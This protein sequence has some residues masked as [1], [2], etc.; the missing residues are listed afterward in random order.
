MAA[1]SALPMLVPMP[2]ASQ[3]K[4]RE[5]LH[6]E[7][8]RCGVGE[9]QAHQFLAQGRRD[10]TNMSAKAEAGRQPTDRRTTG[11]RSEGRWRRR[12]GGRA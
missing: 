2:A 5:S 10:E 7:R 3:G 4:Q 1:A 12:K 9:I 8:K 11:G 6:G